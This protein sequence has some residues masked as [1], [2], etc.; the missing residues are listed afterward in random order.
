MDESIDPYKFA[1]LKKDSVRVSTEEQRLFIA[2]IKNQGDI[3][4]GSFLKSLTESDLY[5]LICYQGQVIQTGYYG[6][7][8]QAFINLDHP[9]YE[10][11][12]DQ[13]LM[14][15]DDI[16]EFRGGMGVAPEEPQTYC[17]HDGAAPTMTAGRHPK[18][19]TRDCRLLTPAAKLIV[20]LIKAHE[21]IQGVKANDGVSNQSLALF[22]QRATHLQA[23]KND[24]SH[25]VITI[26]DLQSIFGPIL[27]LL[28]IA[29]GFQSVVGAVDIMDQ[30]LLIANSIIA[31]KPGFQYRDVVSALKREFL[32]RLAEVSFGKIDH[33]L[34]S[35]WHYLRAILLVALGFHSNHLL[36]TDF[37]G[38]CAILGVKDGKIAG[39]IFRVLVSILFF[40]QT[41]LLLH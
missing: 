31:S 23:A 4:D 37:A 35:S 1:H 3:R 15:V 19:A 32:Q 22:L 6:D 29:V 26:D 2:N 11:E 10:Q 17:W 39:L 33:A 30:L 28:G 24:G 18:K 27:S 20:D 13:D 21:E 38:I 40:E 25:G 36:P 41:H 12:I 8:L 7:D 9:P 5:R 34:F 14:E 16:M